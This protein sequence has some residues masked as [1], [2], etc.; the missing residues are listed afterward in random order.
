MQK[1]TPANEFAVN[2]YPRIYSR[3]L[4]YFLIFTFTFITGCARQVT[5]IV[6]YGSEMNVEI[7][8]RGDF[9][10][11]NNRYFM[12]LAEEES[13]SI[14]LPPPDSLDEFLEPGTSPQIGDIADYYTKYY[15]TWD[16]YI[17]VDNNGYRLAKAPFTVGTQPTYESIALLEETSNKLSFNLGL[18]EIF[19]TS[20]PS[21]IYF[22]IITVD[23]PI[24]DQKFLKDRISPPTYNISK[25]QSSLVEQEDEEDLSIEAGLDIINWK[26]RIE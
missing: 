7:T 10:V 26:V 13:F 8:L 11:V 6:T 14:P 21:N 9:D 12:I 19:G 15:S 22:D 25:I 4:F 17:L 20:V 2:K 16:A 23:Y 18:G 5:Q 3:V 24:D 1:L